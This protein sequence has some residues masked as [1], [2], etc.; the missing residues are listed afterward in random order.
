MGSQN[1]VGWKGSQNSSPPTACHGCG[2]EQVLLLSVTCGCLWQVLLLA[3]TG[4]CA[5]GSVG[6]EEGIQAAAKPHTSKKDG[7]PAPPVP[8]LSIPRSGAGLHG[9]FGSLPA[10]DIPLFTCGRNAQG[11]PK[12]TLCPV[13][14]C[15]HLNPTKDHVP[16][17]K[18]SHWYQPWLLLFEY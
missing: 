12:S 3:G 14:A 8:T 6:P 15:W 11:L 5:M 9:P 13:C 10:Q 2:N 16:G 1:G 7:H 17:L 18:S 4:Q